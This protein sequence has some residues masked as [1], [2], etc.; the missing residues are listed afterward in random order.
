MLKYLSVAG[1][2]LFS[3]IG[4]KAQ[5]V[6]SANSNPFRNLLFINSPTDT[7]TF[8]V[9]Y[10][11]AVGQIS[12]RNTDMLSVI[13]KQT[14]TKFKK[15][16]YAVGFT[17]PGYPQKFYAPCKDEMLFNTLSSKQNAVK[18]LRLNC[19]VYRFYYM[20]ATCNFFY[21]NKASVIN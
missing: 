5:Q 21:I 15:L 16:N 7:I 9:N 10:E 17:I 2:V 13:A 18:R 4:V 20:D 14:G 6:S 1:L 3:V 12:D 11:N 8:V 19:I